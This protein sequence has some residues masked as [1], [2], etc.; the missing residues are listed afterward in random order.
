MQIG[1]PIWAF[2]DI[3]YLGQKLMD[4]RYIGGR[5]LE[6]MKFGILRLYGK[7]ND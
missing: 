7:S 2:Q 6:L 1:G 4:S 5:G 3:G